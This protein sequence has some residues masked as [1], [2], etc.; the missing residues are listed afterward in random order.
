MCG[1]TLPRVYDEAWCS[2]REA[3]PTSSAG[4]SGRSAA[5]VPTPAPRSG[6]VAPNP[7]FCVVPCAAFS[8]HASVVPKADIG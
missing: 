2:G 5:G 6:L 8:A 1:D 4:C 3:V 7:E